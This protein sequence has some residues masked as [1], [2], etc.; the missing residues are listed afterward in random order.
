MSAA[1]GRDG[2]RGHCGF[3]PRPCSWDANVVPF[4]DMTIKGWLFYQ[5]ENNAG[6]L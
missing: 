4:L 1:A 6:A 3:P 2:I 5:G